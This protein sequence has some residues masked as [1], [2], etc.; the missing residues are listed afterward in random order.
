MNNYRKCAGVIVFNKNKKVL[1]CARNDTKGTDWQ[2]PQGGIEAGEQPHLAAM[3]ELKEETSV[4]S[5]EFVKGLENPIR[6]DFPLEV[7]QKLQKRGIKSDGQEMYWSLLFFYGSDE[8]INLNTQEPEFKA[9][10]WVEPIE[11][12]NRIVDFK[13]EVY[14][15]AV[16]EFEPVIKNY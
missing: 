4:V 1:V 10:E 2:F 8:E 15:K 13:K 16:A 3:R 6:Y 14:C 9:Y 12:V 7:K 11:A 5:V